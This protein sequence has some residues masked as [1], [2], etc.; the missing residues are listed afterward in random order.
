MVL[1]KK[2]KIFL[3]LLSLSILTGCALEKPEDTAN[4][5]TEGTESVGKTQE[6]NEDT[7]SSGEE[8]T[9]TVA[10]IE[11]LDGNLLQEMGGDTTVIFN[12][13]TKEITF[14]RMELGEVEEVNGMTTQQSERVEEVYQNY[15]ISVSEDRYTLTAED[16]FEQIFTKLS[17]TVIQDEEGNR[18]AIVE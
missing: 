14:S 3:A 18:Y 1:H 12:A 13:D 11:D 15:L 7:P 10:Q 4:N 16:D 5:E 17:E 9:E 8:S 2:Q 6:M